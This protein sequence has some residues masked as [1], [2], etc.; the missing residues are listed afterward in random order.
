MAFMRR[1]KDFIS[2]VAKQWLCAMH[3][4]WTDDNA[5]SVRTLDFPIEKRVHYTQFTIIYRPRS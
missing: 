1:G 4:V 5:R 3:T 2:S